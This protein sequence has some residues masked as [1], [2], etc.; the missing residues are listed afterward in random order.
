MTDPRSPKARKSSAERAEDLEKYQGALAKL[1]EEATY[2]LQEVTVEY[3]LT[4]NE[5]ISLAIIGLNNRLRQA[6]EGR[7]YISVPSETLEIYQDPLEVLFWGADPA[8]AEVYKRVN[9]LDD[10]Q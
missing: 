4:E 7:V 5:A 1:S 9:G 2:M 6:R 10:P 8:Y 3:D